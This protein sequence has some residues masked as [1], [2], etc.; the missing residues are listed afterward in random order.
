MAT[1][2]PQARQPF[3]D[4]DGSQDG[5]EVPLD[6]ASD[7]DDNEEIYHVSAILAERRRK[8]HEKEYL[9]DWEGYPEE[10]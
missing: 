8:D 5:I 1:R 7:Q 9:V 2:K 10:A 4:D 3:T 6:H